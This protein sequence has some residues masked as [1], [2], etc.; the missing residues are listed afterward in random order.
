MGT[1]F[2]VFSVSQKEKLKIS[3]ENVDVAKT[4]QRNQSLL[5][6]KV[7]TTS[8]MRL[9]MQWSNNVLDKKQRAVW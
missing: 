9:N 8:L 2:R 5:I 1:Q 6:L 4:K 3:A 7:D